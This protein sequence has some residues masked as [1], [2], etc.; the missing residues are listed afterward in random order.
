MKLIWWLLLLII[1]INGV[2]TGWDLNKFMFLP[3]PF[4]TMYKL[5]LFV[6]YYVV[7]FLFVY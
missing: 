2:E 5:K 4:Q 1:I 3:T 7:L 6:L